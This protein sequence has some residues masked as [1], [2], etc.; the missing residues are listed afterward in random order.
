MHKRTLLL[1]AAAAAA[2]PLFAMPALAQMNAPLI[3]RE[4]IF[5][6]PSQTAGRLSPDGRWLSWIA[7]RD[8]VLNIYVAP[9]S[10]PKAAKALTN[11]RLRPIRQYFWAPDSRQ[12]LFINDKGG[13]ENFL[14]YGVDVASGT[15]RTLTPF[16]KTRVQIVGISNQVKDRILIGVNNRDPKWHD[17]HSLDLRTGTLT[18]V[19]MNTGGY[20]GFSADRQLV[21]RGASKPMPD[22]GSAFYRV[23][24]NQV[25]AT[26]HEIVTL[27]DVETTRPAGYTTDGKTLYWLDSRGRDTAALLAQD[28]ATGKKTMIAENARADIG[29]AMAHPQSGR[30]EA[31]AV[32]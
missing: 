30:V 6:N 8:G 9:V 13:D 23:V 31:Y 7:P 24:G 19:I 12:I 3:P 2:L 32:N 27:E 5:G 17:V 14:L 22:G 11:E 4:K 15:Q 20:A 18:P 26:P 21:I 16:E 29:G 1:A 25:E 28:L 10:N